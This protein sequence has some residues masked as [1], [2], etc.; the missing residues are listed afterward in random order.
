MNLLPVQVVLVCLASYAMWR[1]WRLFDREAPIVRWVV[2][3]GLFARIAGGCVMFWISFLKL[4][5]ARSLQ[6]GDGLW[7][8]GYDGIAYLYFA[9]HGAAGGL[10]GIWSIDPTAPSV[11]YIKLLSLFCWL[12]GPVTSVALLLN[13]FAYLATML[14]IVVW[15]RQRGVSTRAALIPM[16]AVA[17]LPTWILWTVQPMKDALFC[18]FVVLFAYAVD[19]Y[20]RA[21]RREGERRWPAILAGAVLGLVALYMLA[22]IRWY[23]ST[24]ALGV[25]VGA[26]AWLLFSR[27][28]WKEWVRRVAVSAIVVILASQLIVAGAGPFLPQQLRTLLQPFSGDA[29]V[30]SRMQGVIAILQDA[31]RNLDSY[32]GAGTQIRSG[33]RIAANTEPKDARPPQVATVTPPAPAR[34]A[35][36]NQET[37]KVAPPPA[38]KPAVPAPKPAVKAPVQKPVPPAPKPV[39][40]APAQKPVVPAPK[41]VVADTK[42]AVNPAPAAKVPKGTWPGQKPALQEERDMPGAEMGIP[43]TFSGRMISGLAAMFLPPRL[44]M[45]L[46]LLTLGGGRGLWLFADVDTILFNLLMIATMISFAVALRRGAWR[47]PF[48]WYLLA[49]T[50]IITLALAYAISNYGTLLRHRE[51]VVVTMSLLALTGRRSKA[52]AENEA[53]RRAAEMPAMESLSRA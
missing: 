41:P 46:D 31:R 14:V 5:F 19:T 39:V 8:F 29:T 6:L 17:C 7:F 13:E 50:A 23:Y 35:V 24:I 34:V 51:M 11:V 33:T 22:G 20:L 25:S 32:R 9:R 16:V 18:F 4:P 36:P 40:T 44:A 30:G 10:P 52:E 27:R 12:F 38:K 48:V 53:P 49:I 2:A 15:A 47:D 37:K 42:P 3:L 43:T 28:G 26:Y 45:S 21:W 1:M